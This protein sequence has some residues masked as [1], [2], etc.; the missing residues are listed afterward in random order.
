MGRHLV[1]RGKDT[2]GQ[3]FTRRLAHSTNARANAASGLRDFFI[4]G[5]GDA[6]LKID[7]ARRSKDGMRMRINKAGEN[8]LTSAVDLFGAT[9]EFMTRY[10]VSGTNGDNLAACGE[11][12]TILDDA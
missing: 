2:S 10:F 1:E 7:Q 12:C 4:T 5:A 6:L 9:R 11:Y 8:D 3:L